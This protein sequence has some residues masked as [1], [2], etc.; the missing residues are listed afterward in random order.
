M[1]RV[2]GMPAADAV[3]RRW[4]LH[5]APGA[6]QSGSMLDIAVVGGAA[7]HG[8]HPAMPYV[9]T[10]HM[11]ELAVVAFAQIAILLVS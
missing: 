3:V 8:A 5:N 7:S 10:P 11:I 1:A 2:C 9:G 4:S 6:A